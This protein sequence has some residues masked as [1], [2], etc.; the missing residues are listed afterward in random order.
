[1]SDEAKRIAHQIAADL[2]DPDDLA[3]IIGDYEAVT[4]ELFPAVRA[5][6]LELRQELLEDVDEDD[7]E[8]L[9][10]EE[11]ALASIRDYLDENGQIDFARLRA[12]AVTLKAEDYPELAATFPEMFPQEAENGENLP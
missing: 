10:D 8:H 12:E 5:A 4:E 1:M 3:D 6:L 2:L 7:D 11:I 9:S